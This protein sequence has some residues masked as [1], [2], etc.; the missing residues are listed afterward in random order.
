MSLIP[1]HVSFEN[2]NLGEFD[3]SLPF[4]TPVMTVKEW[5]RREKRLEEWRRFAKNE[6]EKKERMIPERRLEQ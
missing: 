1:P 5:L 4:R 6:N 2:L 3:N